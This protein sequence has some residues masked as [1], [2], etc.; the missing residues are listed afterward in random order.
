MALKTININR[1][2]LAY[3]IVD[4]FGINIETDDITVNYLC[5]YEEFILDNIAEICPDNMLITELEL[6]TLN[7]EIYPF[8]VTEIE[9]RIAKIIGMFEHEDRDNLSKPT[10]EYEVENDN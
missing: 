4:N 10:K 7:E 8:I 3:N 6:K 9:R 1:E 2:Q 5:E